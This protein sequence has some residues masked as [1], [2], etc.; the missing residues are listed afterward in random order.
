MVESVCVTNYTRVTDV[1]SVFVLSK[2]NCSET[3]AF[4][5]SSRVHIY[6]GQ[7]LR[8]S[9]P[10]NRSMPGARLSFILAVLLQGSRNGW[11]F[12]H[13]AQHVHENPGQSIYGRPAAAYHDVRN[14][15]QALI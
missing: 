10:W 14:E 8:A 15:L 4:R 5:S 6:A 3:E 7:V 2:K 1:N 13:F 12:T 9:V 11:R